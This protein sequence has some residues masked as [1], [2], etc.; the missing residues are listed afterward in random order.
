[1]PQR[2]LRNTSVESSSDQ[3]ASNLAL[4][5]TLDQPF[6]AERVNILFGYFESFFPQNSHI[7]VAVSGGADSMAL[8]LLLIDWAKVNH[9]EIVALTVDH[10]LRQETN[11]E[12]QQIAKWLASRGV[13]HRILC[14]KGKKPSTGIQAAART[15]RY[16]LMFKWCHENNFTK[17]VT[18]HQLEDQLETFLLRAER[19]SGLDGLSSMAPVV[20]RESISLVRPLLNVTKSFLREYLVSKQQSWIED[21]SNQSLAFRRTSMRRIVKN[22]TQGELP[23]AR[24][25]G[26]INNLSFIRL[27]LDDLSKVF[28]K[29]AVRILPAAYGIIDLEALKRL[30]NPILERVLIKII[31]K[32]NGK[33]Y[34][35]RRR[36]IN[37]SIKK[38]ISPEIHNFTLGGCHFI[39]REN[40]LIV[41]RDLRSISA[42]EVV[43]GD[44]FSWDSVFKVQIFGP[45]NK[46][47]KLGALG[48]QGWIEVVQKCPEIRKI[49]IPYPVKISL[50]TLFDEHGVVQ[51]PG[52][53]YHCGDSKTLSFL[54]HKL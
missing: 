1:M 22:L 6:S 38:I 16:N 5:L 53:Q 50:P 52:L 19:G 29:R 43:A 25:L 20:D 4:D 37:Y 26:V 35:P 46:K 15:A 48:K 36:S 51:V 11:K 13:N 49:Q 18:G 27:H 9:Q 45:K 21:P 47:G 31:F 54:M 42:Q 14:W 34:P 44:I 7:A 40:S 2:I 41:C 30:P 3:A 12:T 17:L 23:A 8:C 32:F 33:V 39:Y 28:F 24:I 10:G